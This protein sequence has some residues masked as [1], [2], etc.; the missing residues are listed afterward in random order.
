MPRYFWLSALTAETLTYREVEGKEVATHVLSIASDLEVLGFRVELIT[1]RNGA[2]VRQTFL[3][4]ADLS[5]IWPG[6]SAI[7]P[8]AWS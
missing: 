6:P 2:V 4:A 3:T 7:R 8:G 5:T 1:N